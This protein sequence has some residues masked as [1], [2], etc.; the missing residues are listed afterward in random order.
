MRAFEI[1]YTAIPRILPSPP[2][3]GLD[4]DEGGQQPI[5]DRWSS[6]A[7]IISGV[8]RRSRME[9]GH[10]EKKEIPEIVGQSCSKGNVS[11]EEP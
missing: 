1:E 6:V 3:R 9:N 11:V 5:R 2:E 4:Y 8:Q 10:Y 7:S